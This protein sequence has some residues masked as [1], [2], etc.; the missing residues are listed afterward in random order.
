MSET[1]TIRSGTLLDADLGLRRA[2]LRLSGGRIEEIAPV[3]EPAPRD[4][5][6]TGLTVAP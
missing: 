3:L 1:W 4:L 5:D 2:D 6:A